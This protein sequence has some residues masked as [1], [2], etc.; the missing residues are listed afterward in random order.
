MFL[1]LVEGARTAKA[2]RG[3]RGGKGFSFRMRGNRGRR[4]IGR[5]ELMGPGGR[6]NRDIRS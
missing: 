3:S 5:G 2:G 6:C 4:G 1:L